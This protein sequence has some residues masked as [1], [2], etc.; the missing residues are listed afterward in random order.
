LDAIGGDDPAAMHADDPLLLGQGVQVVAH[1][2][3]R[4]AQLPGDLGNAE[5]WILAHQA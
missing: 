4:D 2:A 5:R 3:L 1:G